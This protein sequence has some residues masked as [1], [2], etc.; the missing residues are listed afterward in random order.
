[1]KNQDPSSTVRS[2]DFQAR[3]KD[4]SLKFEDIRGFL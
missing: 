1:M 4:Y 3:I 2:S